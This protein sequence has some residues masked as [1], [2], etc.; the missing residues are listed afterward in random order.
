MSNIDYRLQQAK[1]LADR[2][3]MHDALS[4]L[5]ECDVNDLDVALQLAYCY[6]NIDTRADYQRATDCLWQVRAAGV[7]SPAWHYRYSV[8]LMYLGRFEESAEH[9][10]RAGALANEDFPWGLLQT[11]CLRYW[12]GDVAGA[13]QA[14]DRGLQ[15]VPG[16]YEFT[17]YRAEV[18]AGKPFEALLGHYIAPEDDQ[19]E[20]ALGRMERLALDDIIAPF[21]IEQMSRG[22]RIRLVMQNAGGLC[23]SA[24][25]AA[26][27]AYTVEAFAHLMAARLEQAYPQLLQSQEAE[28]DFSDTQCWVWFSNAKTAAAFGQSLRECCDD[29]EQLAVLLAQIKQDWHTFERMTPAANIPKQKPI[30]E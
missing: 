28:V 8:A 5:Q 24:F 7:D 26:E 25:A 3:Y 16:D 9:A 14:A 15:L 29:A 10:E 6:I 2:G 17:T 4:L 30:G 1:N 13:V 19:Q 12:K 27:V 20:E 11:I 23:A 21:G 22:M 18:L